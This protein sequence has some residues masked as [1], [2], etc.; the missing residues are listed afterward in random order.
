MIQASS[1]AVIPGLEPTLP[2]RYYTSDAIFQLEKERIFCR[3]WV[4]VGRVE[5]IPNPGDYLQLDL[6]GESVL[7]VRTRQ[8]DVRAFY[9]ICRH[10][11]CRLALGAAG[12]PHAEAPGATGTFPG[13][14]RCTYHSWTYELTG[15]LRSAPFLNAQVDKGPL[16][17]YPV[18]VEIWGGF[19]FVNLTPEEAE[20]RGYTLRS[21]IGDV[22]DYARNYPLADLRIGKRIIYDVRAN[23]KVILENANECY[24]CGGVHPE[25]CEVI[26]AFK[27]YGGGELDLDNGIPHRE[28]AYTMTMTGTTN[29]APFPGL[30]AG[31]QVNHKAHLV[32]PNVHLSFSPDHVAVFNIWPISVDRT[33]IVF[34]W[35]FHKDEIVKPDFDPSD[36][37]DFWDLVNRQD[38]AICEEVQ[39]GS[40]SRRFTVGY[41]AP[42]ESGERSIRAYVSELFGGDA[43]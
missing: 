36:A 40:T 14:I 5:E 26:P 15:G 32:V 18:A 4:C 19:L 42:Q 25:L 43:P 10:R 41:S 20:A 17:L 37:V 11:G 21:Q 34:D 1:N 6:V 16:G 12:N 24:H 23:W 30:S 39:R 3:E 38:W 33:Q 27:A 28:G 2:S 29:R 22:M 8:G 9:N 35:L 31:E 7:V 13:V